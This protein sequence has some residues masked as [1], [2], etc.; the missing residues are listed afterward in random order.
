[1]LRLY[2]M[3]GFL[4]CPAAVIAQTPVTCDTNNLVPPIIRGEGIAEYLGDLALICTGGRAGESI[5]TTLTLSLSTTLTSKVEGGAPEAL[6]LIDEP[7]PGSQ[8]VGLNLFQ[9]TSASR[10]Q[11]VFTI[12]FTAPGSAQRILRFVN[13]RGDASPLGLSPTLMPATINALVAASG[14]IG[15]NQ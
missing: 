13:L 9:A 2:L 14:G 7:A 10:N 11:A 1:M 8:I 6:L 5:S 3:A 4:L 12:T 15:G